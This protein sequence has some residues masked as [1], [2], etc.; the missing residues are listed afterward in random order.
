[1]AKRT[2]NGENINGLGF[3]TALR[4]W[5][6]DEPFTA[7]DIAVGISGKFG[8]VDPDPDRPRLWP[9]SGHRK[10]ESVSIG[11]MNHRLG[12]PEVFT[13][14]SSKSELQERYQTGRLM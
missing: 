12:F 2:I 9:L 4:S 11:A 6:L 1:M 7:D 13:P 10:E 8:G 3:T 5:D 14:S